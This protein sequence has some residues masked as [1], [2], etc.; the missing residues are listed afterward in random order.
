MENSLLSNQ[1]FRNFCK[2]HFIAFIPRRHKEQLALS[3]EFNIN[4]GNSWLIVL[5]GKGET[6]CSMIGDSLGPRTDRN[7]A[8]KFPPSAIKTIEILLKRKDSLQALERKA[9]SDPNDIDTF[10]KFRQRLGECDNHRKSAEFCNSV[11]QN[12][13]LEDA[14]REFYEFHYIDSS[15]WNIFDEK[16]PYSRQLHLNIAVK[17]EQFL[18]A[19][20][21]SE[22]CEKI[23]SLMFRYIYF[24]VFDVPGFSAEGIARL[25]E[26]AASLQ[27]EDQVALNKHIAEIE[28]AREVRIKRL[29]QTYEECKNDKNANKT[30]IGYYAA[31][32]GEIEDTV[33]YLNKN[34][35]RRSLYKD[36]VKTWKKQQA[37]EHKQ[38]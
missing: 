38:D 37:E 20:P 25:K 10:S 22:N 29:R 6:L 14:K 23:V 33:R 5:D 32:L 34:K 27:G 24:G 35:S 18:V 36:A 11:L 2:K 12:P 16:D 28:K 19:Y 4:V 9:L 1:D 26:H 15:A 13:D 17:A 7:D 31:L 21:H 8:S 3:R 30:N